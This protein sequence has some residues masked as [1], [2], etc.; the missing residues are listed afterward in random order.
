MREAKF[1]LEYRLRNHVDSADAR[2]FAREVTA[3]F[4]GGDFVTSNGLWQMLLAADQREAVADFI[5]NNGEKVANY[6]LHMPVPTHTSPR[7]NLIVGPGVEVAI[8]CIEMTADKDRFTIQLSAA[9]KRLL[10]D[11]GFFEPKERT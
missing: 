2:A 6:W 7:L 8:D 4:G 5:Q 3:L 10:Q 1:L 9:A 11:H